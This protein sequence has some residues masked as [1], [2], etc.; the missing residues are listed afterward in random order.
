MLWTAQRNVILKEKDK[1]G[2]LKELFVERKMKI[3]EKIKRYFKSK[4]KQIL[5]QSEQA[6]NDHS[7][8][9][10]RHREG[11]L[12]DFLEEICPKRYS[13]D[14]GIVY[15]MIGRSNETDI[16]IWDELNY[17]KLKQNGSDIFFSEGVKAIIE[18]KSVW[19]SD[20]FEDIKKKASAAINIF[21]NYREG[22]SSKIQDIDNK[23]W[24]LKT[25]KVCQGTLISPRR[26]GT[27]AII[28]YGGQKFNIGNLD[29][30]EIRRI[31]DEYPDIMLFLEAGKII[32]K[33]FE[34]YGNDPLS[35]YGSLLQIECGD[36]ALLMFTSLLIDLLAINSEHLEPPLFLTDY[37]FDLYQEFD[38]K[39]INFD[40]TRPIA[41]NSKTFWND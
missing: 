6:L 22:I 11:V 14:N 30:T 41:G 15:G 2:F 20:E 23:I 35:G 28:Y 27:V 29:D 31:A 7:G 33:D 39:I 3:Q 32:L 25:G 24:G 40:I 17:P 36:D 13:I 12:S 21:S 9:K 26:K 10:G 34:T 1:L 18:V 5:A 4:A 19:S 16:V 8:L 38:R 37:L